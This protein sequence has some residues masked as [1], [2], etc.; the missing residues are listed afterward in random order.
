MM[1]GPYSIK[2]LFQSSRR[3]ANCLVLWS[4][5][6]LVTLD[7]QVWGRWGRTDREYLPIFFQSEGWEDILFHEIMFWGG[8]QV[9]TCR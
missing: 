5:A 9:Y 1:G 3:G 6:D 2:K 7:L 4:M 8:A